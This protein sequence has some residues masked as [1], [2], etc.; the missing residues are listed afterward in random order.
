MSG[1]EWW[2]GHITF[3]K[4]LIELV[5]YGLMSY[6]FVRLIDTLKKNPSTPRPMHAF[7]R[8]LGYLGIMIA[9]LLIGVTKGFSFA[10][11]PN[12]S[13]QFAGFG[14]GW[15]STAGLGSIIGLSVGILVVIILEYLRKRKTS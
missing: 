5:A 13:F 7:L 1:L 11:D 15:E 2:G 3:W 8:I 10:W 4:V 14:I 12:T 9:L 6:G